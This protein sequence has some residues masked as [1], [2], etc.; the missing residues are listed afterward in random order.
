[1]RALESELSW[2]FPA[3]KKQVDSLD[4]A[5][6]VNIDKEGAGW[7]ITVKEEI[8]DDIKK[9]FYY[10]MKYDVEKLFQEYE[11]MIHKYYF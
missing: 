5:G 9:L 10:G 11:V 3:I 2:T 1:M 6:I 4:E 7:S 8:F